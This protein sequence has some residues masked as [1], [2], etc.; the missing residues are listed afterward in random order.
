MFMRM[1]QTEKSKKKLQELAAEPEKKYCWG[2]LRSISHPS[3]SMRS[4]CSAIQQD[5]LLLKK[6]ASGI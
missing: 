3:I 1:L 4:S 5:I 6:S 2:K